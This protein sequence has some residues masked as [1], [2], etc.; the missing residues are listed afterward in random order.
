MKIK[1]LIITLCVLAL[2]S[3][4][5]DSKKNDESS[6][7]PNILF[8]MSDDHAYQAISAYDNKLTNTPNIDR[9]ADEGMLFTNAC[10]T[11]SI[12]APSRAVILTGKHS[13]INGKTD[14][15]FPFNE[16]NVTFPQIF[17]KAG[18]Q[19][20]MF[21][22]LHF[23][24]NPKGFDE[25]KILIGQGHYYNPTF[26]TKTEGK[27]DY[28]GYVTDIVTDMTLNWLDKERD[29]SKPFMLMY[30]HKAPHR[31]WL[32][33]ARHHKEF[34]KKTFQEP[35]T[36]F[37]DYSNRGTAAHT[38][39]MN[40]LEHMNWA[41][42]S[43]LYPEVMA[44]L[45]IEETADWDIAAFH[46]ERDRM[47]DEQKAAWDA[48][49]KPVND[50]FIKNY[51]KMDSTELMKWRYQRYMQDYL[52]TIASVD[53]NVGRVLD[54]LDENKLAD[55]TLVV[56][57][58]DQGFYL[59]EHGWFD[60]RFAYNESFKTPLLIRWP[61]K[62]KPGITNDE[63]VQNLDFAQ[64]FLEA[65]GI[66]EPEDMQGESLMPLLTGNDAEWDREAVYY[67]YYEYPS[68]HMVKRHYAI[69]TKEYKLIHYYY[70]VDEWELFD[71]KNDPHELKNVYDDP[72]YKDIVTQLKSDLKDLRIKYKDS[73]EIDQKLL[74]K[75]L[76]SK[77]N[78]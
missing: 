42:D 2:F 28:P 45:N 69:I 16:D 37:D 7:R 55:N 18:Y 6:K 24:N 9:L 41:G 72:E 73:S 12:C 50:E 20:A 48:S 5:T 56:Y 52:G 38:A 10:V 71:R 33:A 34:T 67:H 49:Y 21:G 65:A 32:P 46:K 17:Q 63:M 8:I 22:K 74:R 61:N 14:N 23:G 57:T 68:I 15:Y 47:T 29:Q 64:T 26:I 70:D 39:E 62:I 4:S 78:K 31:E 51:A 1:Y 75:F 59:G 66:K 43:K 19:T 76:E 60:K 13:H 77:Y 30:L 53:E 3:C 11:N 27:K 25:F 40:I 35:S 58:S 54:Y 44:K 36:L